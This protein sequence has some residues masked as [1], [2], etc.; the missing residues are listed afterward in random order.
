[1]R[2]C[3]VLLLK[4]TSILKWNYDVV[5]DEF[6]GVGRYKWISKSSSDSD[7]P[8]FYTKGYQHRCKRRAVTACL[9]GKSLMDSGDE[10]HCPGSG[11][12]SGTPVEYVNS[13]TVEVFIGQADAPQRDDLTVDGANRSYS[14]SELSQ[15]KLTGKCVS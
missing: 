5:H 7:I 11:A 2:V 9:T 6:V 8:E 4:F 1:M 13:C 3:A 15:K 14:D 12:G 10:I